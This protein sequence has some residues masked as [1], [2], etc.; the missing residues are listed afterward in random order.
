MPHKISVEI[1]IENFL[2]VVTGNYT[3]GRPVT[4]LDPAESPDYEIETVAILINPKLGMRQATELEKFLILEHYDSHIMDAL[5][6][7][8]GRYISD[9]D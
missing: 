8:I 2:I 5:S 4:R 9:P 3:E 6:R 1:A 7:K